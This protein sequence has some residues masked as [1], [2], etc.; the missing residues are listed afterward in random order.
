MEVWLYSITVM[1]V[2]EWKYLILC[3]FWNVQDDTWSLSSL[4]FLSYN[5]WIAKSQSFDDWLEAFISDVYIPQKV[6]CCTNGVWWQLLGM[7]DAF[8][9]YRQCLLPGRP[10]WYTL[11]AL[12]RTLRYLLPN[13]LLAPAAGRGSLIPHFVGGLYTLCLQEH[14]GTC[15]AHE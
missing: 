13:E 1:I 5:N 7:P 12:Q 14:Q 10:P 15:S 11:F 6:Q 3:S 2:V 9:I 8:N 4:V